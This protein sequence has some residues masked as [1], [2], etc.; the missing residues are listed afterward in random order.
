[1]ESKVYVASDD[2]ISVADIV[3]PWVEPDWESGL[4]KRCRQAWSTPLRDLSR[5]E[6]ATL[7]R[8]R[9][10]VEHILPIARQRVES[11][12][13]DDTEMYDGELEAAIAY[14]SHAA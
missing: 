12:I 14:A 9:I 13:D 4:I 1:M 2:T 11:G 3:G 5:E 10:A 8:Q 6:L 7:L